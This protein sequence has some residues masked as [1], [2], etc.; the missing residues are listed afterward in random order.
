MWMLDNVTCYWGCYCSG[1]WRASSWWR[2]CYYRC[3]FSSL[4][5]RNS[6]WNWRMGAVGAQAGEPGRPFAPPSEF[7]VPLQLLCEV[8]ISLL[9][10][11][12]SGARWI[13]NHTVCLENDNAVIIRRKICINPPSTSLLRFQRGKSIGKSLR[14]KAWTPVG[15]TVV[16][17]L[18]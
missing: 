10:R 17:H 12:I 1:R 4:M 8:R 18:P 3:T 7:R 14:P 15:C 13:K 16:L 11:W 9:L 2:H 6:L 5:I